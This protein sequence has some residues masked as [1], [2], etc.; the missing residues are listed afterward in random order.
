VSVR[1]FLVALFVATAVAPLSRSADS[2]WPDLA[3]DGGGYWSL[4]VPVA[5]SGQSGGVPNA[6]MAEVVVRADGPAAALVGT[7]VNELRVATADG[8]E[9]K[10][11]L[12]SAGGAPRRAGS[13]AAGD[14]LF[15]PLQITS[16]ED[17]AV[18]DIATADAETSSTLRETDVVGRGAWRQEYFVYAGNRSAWTVPE[19]MGGGTLRNTGFEDGG[20]GPAGWTAYGCDR[21]H[22]MAHQKGVARS[23]DRCAR[24]EVDAGAQP[25]WVK[26]AQSGMPIRGGARYRFAGW[27]KAENVNGRAGWYVHVHGQGKLLLNRTTG[28]GGTFDWRRTSFEFTTPAEASAFSLGTVLHGTGKAWF[29]DVSVELLDGA[30]VPTVRVGAAQRRK[31]RSMGRELPWSVDKTW[32]WRVPLKVRHFGAE[33]VTG[34]LVRFDSRRLQ[35]QLAKVLGGMRP[36][37]RLVD[38]RLPQDPLPVLVVAGGPKTEL[39]TVLDMLPRTELTLWL[40]LSEDRGAPGGS[41]EVA[42]D[43]WSGLRRVNLLA[44]GSMDEAGADSVPGWMSTAPDARKRG[45]RVARVKRENEDAWCLRLHVPDSV[46]EPGW[47]GWRQGVDVKPST[48]YLLA[49]EL[50]TEGVD[51]DV[52]IHGHLLRADGK[53]TANGFI[54]TG[55]GL[56]GTCDWTRLSTVVTTPPDCARLSVHLT[57]QARGI[58]W[59]DNLILARVAPGLVGDIEPRSVP[60]DVAAWPVNP[61]VKVFREDVL[62]RDPAVLVDVRVARNTRRAFQL[63]LR[64]V[65]DR[66]VSVTIGE[67][68]GPGGATIAPE[69]IRIHRV[70][71]VPIDFPIGYAGSEAPRTHRLRPTRRGNDGWAGMWPDPLVPL[72]AD[73][74]VQ[75]RAGQ[76]QP[77]WFD[78]D[79][80][81]DAKPGDYRGTIAVRFAS[82]VFRFPLSVRVWRFA[83][84][85][86]PRLPAIYDL[87]NGPGVP[88]VDTADATELRKWCAFLAAYKVSPGMCIVPPK[89]A[90]KDGRMRMETTEFDAFCAYLFDELGVAR[91]YTPW[92]FYACGWAR[93]PKKVFGFE[94]FSDDYDRAWTSAYEQFVRHIT[95]RGWR[96]RFVFYISDEPHESSEGTIAGLARLADMARKI[97]PDVPIY[98]STW[99]HIKGLEDHITMWGIGIHGSFPQEK[100][101]A[102]RVKGDRFWYTTD[103]HMCT[104]TP[105]L[106]VE[107]LLPWFCFRYGCEAYE[108]WGVSWWTH[109]PW[110]RGWHTF[111]RQSSDGVKYRWVRYPNGDGFLAYPGAAQGIDGPLP[112]IRLLAAREGVDDYEVFCRLQKH[113]EAGSAEAQRALDCVGSLV[114]T[115]NRG[116]RYSTDI[117]PDPGAVLDARIA[118]GET[119]DRLCGK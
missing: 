42:L 52:R 29:D 38:P 27:T 15:L 61:L 19:W 115:P 99:R 47:P 58:V 117:M 63:A 18:R 93:M 94:A 72:G 62:P 71:Y 102:R 74:A 24:C 60:R 31:L 22:R 88:A 97:A 2:A 109:D 78:L 3:Y 85:D 7:G 43:A 96:D 83:M 6:G 39:Y 64:S 23:G 50:K 54:S 5:V 44:N 13:V 116:G 10:F 17:V 40:Y 37:L 8:I 98:S 80:P 56:S 101:D 28:E 65:E 73:G 79:I 4:R 45:I 49:G 11:G 26:Y 81:V 34:M 9:L 16:V 106:A 118:A 25:S 55:R 111:I 91:L 114:T 69:A 53:H 51:E 59:H 82:E 67:L 100:V 95:K 57:M 46:A 90:L 108:F 30:G 33:P 104:D 21:A 119:L 68:A 70:D 66:R 77:L 86:H 20:A 36:V 103:G 105:Y 48:R 92:L 75:L 89:F 87:R 107:T 84:P 113:A 14:R 112:S 32:G 110:E 1:P 35:N 41:R 12:V 76:T